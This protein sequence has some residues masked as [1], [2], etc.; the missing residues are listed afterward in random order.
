[1][2][3]TVFRRKNV[4]SNDAAKSRPK[5]CFVTANE[6]DQVEASSSI[7]RRLAL[8]KQ[9]GEEGWKNRVSKSDV[10]KE[11]QANPKDDE[12]QLRPKKLN[13]EAVAVSAAASVGARGGGSVIANRLSCLMESQAQWRSRVNESDA[14]QFTVAS[15]QSRQSTEWSAFQSTIATSDSESNMDPPEK[16]V[17]RGTPKRLGLRGS[18]LNESALSAVSSKL[19]NVL[20]PNKS[21]LSSPLTPFRKMG[22][23]SCTVDSQPLVSP[24]KLSK[25]ALANCSSIDTS[26]VAQTVFLTRPDDEESFGSFYG[27]DISK[28]DHLLKQEAKISEPRLLSL[29]SVATESSSL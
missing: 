20:Q 3:L 29:D 23:S 1:M 15:K 6:L 5:S 11:I 17:L 19:N 14:K 12:V 25:P 28:L 7:A 22:A 16:V 27:L 13:A 2:N 21:L 24:V 10:Q 4:S 26:A 9:N 18:T 8:L